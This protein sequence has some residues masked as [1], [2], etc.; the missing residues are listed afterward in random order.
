MQ[1][2]TGGKQK[3]EHNTAIRKLRAETL[4]MPFVRLSGT[5]EGA[6]DPSR[7]IRAKLLYKLYMAGW[8]IYNGNGD[9][10]VTLAN[11]QKKVVE[12]DAFVFMPRPDLQDIF[13]AASIFVGFQTGDKELNGK[14]MVVL[15]PKGSWEPFLKLIE[16]LRL[17]GTVSQDPKKV[18]RVVK[19]P[20]DVLTAI[21]ELH[22]ISTAET[23][24]KYGVKPQPST[25]GDPGRPKPSFSVCVF[26]SASLRRE[27]YIQE[28]FGLGKMIAERGWGCVTGAG[29]TGIM[30]QVVA[31][32]VSADGWTG[33]SNVPH[34]IEMEGLPD[35]INTFWSR[36]DIYTRMEVMIQNSDAFIIMP[37]GM[38]TVQEFLALV[39][40]RNQNAPAMR[41]KPVIV[42]DRYDHEKKSRF[43]EPLLKLAEQYKV[44][45][46]FHVVEHYSEAVEVVKN[47]SPGHASS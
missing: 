11:I 38:G 22:S 41:H 17:M 18:F 24:T 12:S 32:A 27:D 39:L 46:A 4:T 44:G 25:P 19:K 26:C 7:E 13:K 20:K 2:G 33:G 29:R 9:Q 8:D 45:E 14:P 15:N 10:I 5:V 34:I 35:G 43:W 42:V 31:G 36:P 30:G 40:L 16:H 1:E 6:T 37:G 3:H 28:G 21:Q 23:E 47:V